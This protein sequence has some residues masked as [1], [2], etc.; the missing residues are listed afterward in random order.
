MIERTLPRRIDAL[1]TLFETIGAFYDAERLDRDA[2]F[3]V[4][5]VAEELFTNVVRHG[6]GSGDIG[7]RL[8]REG[9]GVAL[10]LVEHGTDAFDPRTVPAPDPD[11]PLEQRRGG[12]MGLHIVRQLAELRYHHHERTGTLTAVVPLES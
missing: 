11:L 12:G 5:L 2:A 9:A 10:S 3:N 4:E 1:E 7:V 8:E 6:H